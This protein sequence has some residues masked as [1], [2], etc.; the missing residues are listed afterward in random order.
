MEEQKSNCEVCH[1][2]ASYK[3]LAIREYLYWKIGLHE[4]QYYLGRC[5]ILLKRHIEDFFDISEQE[6]QEFYPVAKDLRDVVRKEF[7]ASMFNYATLGNVV[8]HVHLHFIPRYDHLV[9]FNEFIF[10]DKRWGRNYTPYDKNF[11]VPKE[12]ILK[13]RDTIKDHLSPSLPSR[14]D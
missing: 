2:P 1:P 6:L 10:E 3:E 7:S 9:T 8:K 13:I 4:N 12:T 11:I 14:S 5:V